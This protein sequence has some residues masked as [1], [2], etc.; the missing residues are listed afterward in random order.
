ML[1]GMM[2]NISFRHHVYQHINER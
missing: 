2:V 1:S